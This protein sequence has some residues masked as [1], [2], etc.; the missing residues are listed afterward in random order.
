MMSMKKSAMMMMMMIITIKTTAK[1]KTK[2]KVIVL[3]NQPIPFCIVIERMLPLS[4]VFF[5]MEAETDEWSSITVT[6]VMNTQVFNRSMANC[7][8]TR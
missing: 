6:T 5:K 2:I 4:N 3:L 7:G 1:K 8:G